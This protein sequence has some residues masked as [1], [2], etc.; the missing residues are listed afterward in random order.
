MGDA[1]VVI[2]LAILIGLVL[3]VRNRPPAHRGRSMAGRDDPSAIGHF[4]LDPATL[5]Y[6]HDLPTSPAPGGPVPRGSGPPHRRR[7]RARP[8]RQPE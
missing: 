7:G 5:A 1:V 6:R 3:L 8:N 2:G 4:T